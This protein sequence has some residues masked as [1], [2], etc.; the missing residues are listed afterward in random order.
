MR[1]IPIEGTLFLGERRAF[2]T[3]DFAVP[4]QSNIEIATKG[5]QAAND[6]GV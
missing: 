3:W 1:D 5:A 6:A 2:K 4:V